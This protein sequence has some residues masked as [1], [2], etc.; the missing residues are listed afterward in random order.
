MFPQR[1]G[2]KFWEVGFFY[3]RGPGQISVNIADLRVEFLAGW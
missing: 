3:S 1:I 2:E